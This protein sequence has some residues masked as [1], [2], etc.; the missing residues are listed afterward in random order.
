MSVNCRFTSKENLT[1]VLR[2]SNSK[3]S[4]IN[5]AFFAKAVKTG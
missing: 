4:G 1:R 2:V 3:M 5:D